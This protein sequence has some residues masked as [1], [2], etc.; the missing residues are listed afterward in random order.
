MKY[1]VKWTIS[2]EYEV[3]SAD[4]D[5]DEGSTLSD[6]KDAIL[7]DPMAGIE[8][9]LADKIPTLEITEIK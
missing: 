1:K 8:E 3:T 5:L 9:E 4:L 2:G 6:V 7:E